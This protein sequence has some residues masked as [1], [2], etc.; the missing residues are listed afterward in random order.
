MRSAQNRVELAIR[1]QEDDPAVFALRRD[2]VSDA[3][4]QALRET[5]DRGVAGHVVRFEPQPA[6]ADEAVALALDE[7]R[8]SD[9]VEFGVLVLPTKVPSLDEGVA[10]HRARRQGWQESES[11]L[12]FFP[13]LADFRATGLRLIPPL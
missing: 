4:R 8:A 2:L 5:S 11:L 3:V 13:L 7:H 6:L 10:D 9:P 12:R 1:R